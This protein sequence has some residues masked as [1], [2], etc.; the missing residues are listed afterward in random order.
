M[1]RKNHIS[2][3][4][5][6]LLKATILRKAP[7][8]EIPAASTLEIIRGMIYIVNH[9]EALLYYLDPYLSV[10]Q[11][12]SLH[13]GIYSTTDPDLSA[14]CHFDI[15]NFPHLLLL[16]TGGGPYQDTGWLIKL[17]TPYNRRHLV[18]Q[19]NLKEFYDLIRTPDIIGPNREIAIR[20]V[21]SG[22]DFIALFSQSG[23]EIAALYFY[24]E[25]FIEFIQGDMESVP[26]PLS[27]SFELP[28][29]LVATSV[30]AF[31]DKLFWSANKPGKNENFI[32]WQ[33]IH[34][35]ERLRG[36][37]STPFRSEQRYG[38]LT[39]LD[40]DPY[41]G[42]IHALRVSDQPEA[43]IY[44]A[45]ALGAGPSGEPELLLIDLI[46]APRPEDVL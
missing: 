13:D 17:P 28:D 31:E 27:G 12:I 19:R 41:K 44:P 33:N 23:R 10:K 18:R 32:G 9:S 46:T 15:N 36:M 22:S 2:V 24:K 42:A 6:T 39:D 43:D 21:V 30:S 25:E 11:R 45:L 5:L 14:C 29:Q 16:S 8:P 34:N 26:F 40:G 20:E 1:D 37:T 35:F 38:V 4:P 3:Y 7:L